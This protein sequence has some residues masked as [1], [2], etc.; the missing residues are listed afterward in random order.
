MVVFLHTYATDL[1]RD[2]LEQIGQILQALV[3]MCVGNIENQQVVFDKLLMDPL[4]RILQLPLEHNAC[5][6]NDDDNVSVDII[7]VVIIVF[8]S[9][10]VVNVHLNLYK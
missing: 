3:E 8:Y 6:I 4:N 5:A 7:T 1:T 2:N 9:V 10:Q